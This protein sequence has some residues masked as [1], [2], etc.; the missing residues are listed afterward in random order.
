M[1]GG[2]RKIP[3]GRFDGGATRTGFLFGL[4]V[5]LK[6]GEEGVD[7]FAVAGVE[8]FF[9]VEE[10]GIGRAICGGDEVGEL[11]DEARG[12]IEVG[13]SRIVKKSDGRFV[14]WSVRQIVEVEFK[15]GLFAA[16]LE[17]TDEIFDVGGFDDDGA[18]GEGL[19]KTFAD[20][21]GAREFGEARGVWDLHECGAAQD[22]LSIVACDGVEPHIHVRGKGRGSDCFQAVADGGKG[23]AVIE[24]A[25][26]EVGIERVDARAGDGAA[27]DGLEGGKLGEGIESC[28]WECV[29]DVE[30]GWVKG[31]ARFFPDGK[32]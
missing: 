30:G 25:M 14:G 4:L 7:G 13:E 29:G 6:F 5:G 9:E 12:E 26:D 21:F 32:R 15:A 16:P 8:I 20:L 2:G 22:D 24:G 28:K 19:L 18:G 1:L 31:G 17:T 23:C 10:E 27:V 3:F 11:M